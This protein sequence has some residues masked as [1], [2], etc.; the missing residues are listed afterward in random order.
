MFVLLFGAGWL[1]DNIYAG[2]AAA[3]IVPVAIELAISQHEKEKRRKNPPP[4][5]KTKAPRRKL[6]TGWT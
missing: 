4:P 1:F 6:P 2:L 5:E 3:V